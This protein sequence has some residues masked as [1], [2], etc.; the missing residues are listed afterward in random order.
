M[1]V[2]GKFRLIFPINL[3]LTVIFFWFFLKQIF[4]GQLNCIFYQ[5]DKICS[6]PG[7]KIT[8]MIKNQSKMWQLLYFQLIGV[9]L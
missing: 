7:S 6:V 1:L 3:T 9:L 8:K 2:E 4:S 5:N